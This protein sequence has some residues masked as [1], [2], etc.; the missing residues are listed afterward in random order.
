MEGV[1]IVRA[2]M[3][4]SDRYIYE[5]KKEFV[6][7]NFDSIGISQKE[8][9]AIVNESGYSLFE[10]DFSKMLSNKAKLTLRWFPILDI[11]EKMINA[12]LEKVEELKNM[13]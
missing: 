1:K 3:S 12:E 2:V 9:V 8:F 6:L 4:S 13:R 11:A 10:S 5:K 7:E